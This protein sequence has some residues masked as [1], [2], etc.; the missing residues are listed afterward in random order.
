MSTPETPQTPVSSTPAASKASAP[1]EIRIISHS[2]LYY[3][4]PIWFFGLVFA[5]WTFLEGNRLAIIPAG[6]VAVKSSIQGADGNPATKMTIYVEG[7]GHQLA[8]HTKALTPEEQ[9][10][11]EEAKTLPNNL[12][13]GAEASRILTRVS[14]KS[15]MGPLFLIILSLVIII[16]NVPLRGLWSLVAII[17]CVTLSLFISLFGW[18]DDIFNAFGGLH[19]Y[20]NM[21]GYIFLAIVLL[22]A[23]L[24]AFFVFDR[25][26][27]IV[28]TPGQIRVCEQIGG[29]EKVYDTMGMTIEKHRDDWFRHIFLG[30]GSGD[31]TVRTAG[32]DRHEFRMP[33]VAL[34]GFKIGPIEQMLRQKPIFQSNDN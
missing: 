20:I 27:Y 3:W 5:F 34:I 31:L 32:A 12:E 23:W 28:F 1:N 11:R 17:G 2:S 29:R 30:F 4:W 18:W 10:K 15:W 6:S 21:A 33:N 13:M 14:A 25:R 9:K 19:I 26:S 7:D 24:V 22:I 8:K 16:T